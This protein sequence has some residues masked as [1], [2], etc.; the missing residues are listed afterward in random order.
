MKS[1]FVCVKPKTFEASEYF[2]HEMRS[3]H[4]CKVKERRDGKILLSSIA[5][6]SGNYNFWVSE[7]EDRNWKL[8]NSN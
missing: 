1:E 4:S 7:S 3:L 6:I 8:L 5:S 2:V